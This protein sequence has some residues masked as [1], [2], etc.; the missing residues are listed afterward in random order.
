MERAADCDRIKGELDDHC[1]SK[2]ARSSE[3]VQLEVFR[4]INNA[5]SKPWWQLDNLP[6]WTMRSLNRHMK[7]VPKN[8]NKA[9][10]CTTR[11]ALQS[12]LEQVPALCVRV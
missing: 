5:I 12:L 11:C 6:L 1:W 10:E 8:A 2:I 4:D 7:E 3:T 9:T